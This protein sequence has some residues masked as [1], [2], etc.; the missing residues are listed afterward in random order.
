MFC[1]GLTINK[2]TIS[3]PSDRVSTADKW[4]VKQSEGSD[5]EMD[6]HLRTIWLIVLVHIKS[7]AGKVRNYDMGC[8]CGQR[9]VDEQKEKECEDSALLEEDENVGLTT[10]IICLQLRI[11]YNGFKSAQWLAL[12]VWQLVFWLVVGWSF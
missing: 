12:S 8:D 4:L 11:F 5:E 9:T 7:D 6:L 2:I 10:L 1:K 3:K